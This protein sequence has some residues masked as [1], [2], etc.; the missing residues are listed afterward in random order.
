MAKDWKEGW[1]LT[2]LCGKEIA[3]RVGYWVGPDE[4]N[5]IR[6]HLLLD[7][8]VWH[9]RIYSTRYAALSV[10][11]IRLENQLQAFRDEMRG[12]GVKG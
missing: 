10:L 5:H 9:G 11:C 8:Q 1:I 3:A 6:I 7:E 12:L 4:V 2:T